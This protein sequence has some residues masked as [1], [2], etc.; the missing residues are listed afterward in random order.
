MACNWS[1]NSSDILDL[2]LTQIEFRPGFSFPTMLNPCTYACSV[3]LIVRVIPKSHRM[4]NNVD[5]VQI[6]KSLQK[7]FCC[8]FKQWQVLE[9]IHK[10]LKWHSW[11][12][13]YEILRLP[14]LF[15]D[16][17]LVPDRY[18]LSWKNERLQNRYLLELEAYL[19]LNWHRCINSYL[20]TR[21][22]DR[23]MVYC[24]VIITA[25]GGSC[26]TI[27]DVCCTTYGSLHGHFPFLFFL[28]KTLVSYAEQKSW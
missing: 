23:E 16:L 19:A 7:C 21:W 28:K 6:F 4:N 15:G 5:H 12:G 20:D 8:L 18:Q 11:E 14:M 9:M 24:N 3:C 17:S 13:V 22:L 2:R 25:S 27:V 10:M 1:W 26:G